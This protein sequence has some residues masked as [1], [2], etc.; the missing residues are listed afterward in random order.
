MNLHESDTL[1]RWV[2]HPR[3]AMI[4]KRCSQF[5]RA[6]S[7]LHLGVSNRFYEPARPPTFLLTHRINSNNVSERSAR[8]LCLCSPNIRE[9]DDQIRFQGF[10]L[11]ELR[12]AET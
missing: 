10:N 1:I 2:A 7:R 3:T 6:K 5:L 8:L 12:G 11:V 9:C 4:S